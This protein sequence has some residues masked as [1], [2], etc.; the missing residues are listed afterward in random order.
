MATGHKQDYYELLGVAKN[1]TED[2]LKKAT[3]KGRAVSSDKNPGN[4]AGDVR[5]SPRPMRR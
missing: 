5:K 3:A 1:A 2:D 4:K